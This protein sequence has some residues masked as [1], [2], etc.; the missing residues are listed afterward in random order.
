MQPLKLIAVIE[1]NRDNRL[2]MTE[3][4]REFYQVH[5]YQNGYEALEGISQRHPDLVILDISLPGMD[6]PE[7]LLRIRASVSLQDI[8]VIA[9]TAHA[10]LGDREKY[11][12]SGF[13]GYVAKPI[14]DEKA[15]LALIQKYIEQPHQE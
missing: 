13:D 2:I 8:P 3:L 1:D 15:F 10:M 5:E 4:L 6:G 12:S 7:V 14:I 9:L 11:L